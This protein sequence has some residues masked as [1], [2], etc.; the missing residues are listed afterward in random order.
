MEK[1]QSLRASTVA[2]AVA[3]FM[4]RHGPHLAMR[5]RH[6][7]QRLFD[8]TILPVFGKRRIHDVNAVEVERFHAGMV[9]TPRKANLAVAILSKLMNWLKARNYVPDTRTHAPTSNV[10]RKITAS[11]S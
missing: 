9:A 11:G 8:T 4:S 5:T 3:L 7:Y 2:E 6:D 1:Q 10:S